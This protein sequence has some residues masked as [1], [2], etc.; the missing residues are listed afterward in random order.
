M[1]SSSPA[2]TMDNATPVL[3]AAVS[4]RA[5]AASARRAGSVPLFADFFGEEDTPALAQAHVR[6][7][8]SIARG[9]VADKLLDP[10]A[11][12]A[13]PRRPAGTVCGTGFEDRPEIL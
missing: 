8:P 7:D 12:L 9:R 5:L 10:P 3:I 2:N 11:T 13:S 6:P 4:G 1:H